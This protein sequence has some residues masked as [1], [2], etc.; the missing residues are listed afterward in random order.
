ERDHGAE[1]GEGRVARVVDEL[2]E[3]VDDDATLRVCDEVDLAPRVS[4]CERAEL[5]AQVARLAD[6]IGPGVGR[7]VRAAAGAVGEPADLVGVI[8]ERVRVE[9]ER[10]AGTRIGVAV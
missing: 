8:A 9:A 7:A 1:R 10:G 3:R 2:E 4:T 5:V 6:E